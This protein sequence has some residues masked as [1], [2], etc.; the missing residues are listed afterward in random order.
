MLF[1]HK[2][3]SLF[4]LFVEKTKEQKRFSVK[5]IPEKNFCVPLF[6]Q[7]KAGQNSTTYGETAPT[8][9]YNIQTYLFTLSQ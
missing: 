4:Q 5:Q 1:L 7:Q 6:F 9:L 8:P 2:L 3:L